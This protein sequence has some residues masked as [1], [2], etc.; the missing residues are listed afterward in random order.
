MGYF[1]GEL[2]VAGEGGLNFVMRSLNVGC[3]EGESALNVRI[4]ERE[5]EL[6]IDGGRDRQVAEPSFYHFL[7]LNS[8]C[9]V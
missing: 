6:M 2:N 1:N 7:S 8:F 3:W 4:D 9:N 5:E